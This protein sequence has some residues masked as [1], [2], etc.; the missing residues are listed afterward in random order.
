V[1]IPSKRGLPLIRKKQRERLIIMKTVLP[2]YIDE[3]KPMLLR[4]TDQRLLAEILN[5]LE[6]LI[7]LL[8]QKDDVKE[9]QRRRKQNAV[10]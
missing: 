5:T 6:K 3:K 1:A 9:T 2:N 8:S 7:Q 4:T 10:K